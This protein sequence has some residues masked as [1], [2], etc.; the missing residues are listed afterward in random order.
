M[1]AVFGPVHSWRLGRTLGVDIGA[2]DRKYCSFDCIYC[3]GD[4][5]PRRATR[6][7]HYVDMWA[8]QC[9]LRSDAVISGHVPFTDYV[10]FTGRCE[11]TLARNLGQAIELAKSMLGLP[12]AVLTNSSLMPADDVK[13]DLAKADMVVAKL[14]AADEGL[15][16]VINRPFVQYGLAAIVDALREFRRE[17]QGKFVI[18]TT[19]VDKNTA[20]IHEVAAIAHD[21]SPDEIQLNSRLPG[22]NGRVSAM[23][24]EVETIRSSFPDLNVTISDTGDQLSE[25]VA[26]VVELQRSGRHNA[27]VMLMAAGAA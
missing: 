4:K 25:R 26:D 8:L 10:A 27:E 14:D 20:S 11:P 23:A 6:R 24:T 12:V 19:V 15:F 7:R 1:K 9:L 5:R 16:Q 13:H 18:Q 17:F 22:G 2:P 3:P 21:L